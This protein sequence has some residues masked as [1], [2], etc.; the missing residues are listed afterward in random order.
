MYLG[1]N[2]FKSNFPKAPAFFFKYFGFLFSFFFIFRLVFLAINKAGL[3]EDNTKYLL[4]SLYLGAKFDLR[5]AA[6][7]CFISFFVVLFPLI[8]PLSNKYFKFIFIFISNLIF[9]VIISAYFSDFGFYAYLN[10]RLS[11]SALKF[12]ENP[13]ISAKMV[14]QT[15]P[16]IWGLLV[17]I[18]L[19]SIHFMFLK[20]IIKRY[21]ETEQILTFN[22]RSI[23]SFFVFVLFVGALYGKAAR[24]P[25]RWSEAY[26]TPDPFI[27]RFTINP[28]LNFFDT[29]KYKVQK[30]DLAKVK[31]FYPLMSSVLKV[32]EKDILNRN[33]KRSFKAGEVSYEDYNI[34]II[35]MESMASNKTS[36]SGNILNPTPVLAKLAA[37]SLFF[38]NHFTPTEATARGVFASVTSN[39]DVTQGRGS[40]S[41]NPFVINQH[42]VMNAF[43]KHDKFYFLGGSANWGNIR[44]VFSNNVTDINIFEEGSYTAPRIDVWGISDIDLF[45]EADKALKES[46]ARTK[47]PFMAFIQ[48][49]GFHRPY[50][51]PEKNYGFEKSNIT[52]SDVINNGFH[53]KEEFN[54]IKLQDHALGLF[55]KKAKESGYYDKTIFVIYGDH[56]LPCSGNCKD[57]Q[58]IKPGL[59]KHHLINHK[60]PLVFHAKNFIA[61]AV[62]NMIASQVDI[63]PTLASLVGIPYQTQTLGQNILAK[64][65]ADNNVAFIY[66]WH[67]KPE[68]FGVVND[69]Y[70]LVKEAGEFKLFDYLSD[71]PLT[72]LSMTNSDVFD[73]LKDLAQ[74]YMETS[75]YL[76]YNNPKL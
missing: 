51:V 38:S 63:M 2:S 26:F 20:K 41:R 74:G 32:E 11:A 22:S 7:A 57:S 59:I 1:S 45:I 64:K 6:L 49:S 39:A 29:L 43:K 9:S 8:R 66:T 67:A 31:K 3:T 34:V 56:G 55:I 53:S 62:N 61:P 25:L 50:T 28:V 15:Y 73:E 70:F 23:C 17:F 37:E 19:F 12:F 47:K 65:E 36:L 60:V 40:S 33:F 42:S 72:D 54:S 46:H 5:L 76:I 30:F 48:T 71:S 27:S 21:N 52:D 13:I 35:M 14:W 69:K 10:S 58:N 18:I 4:N 24:Y 16:V 75:R 68:R 44:G